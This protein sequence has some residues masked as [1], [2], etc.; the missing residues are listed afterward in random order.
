MK[1]FSYSSYA[2]SMALP[3]RIQ[4]INQIG[5]FSKAYQQVYLAF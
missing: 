4:I 5:H 3:Y 1:V 2:N